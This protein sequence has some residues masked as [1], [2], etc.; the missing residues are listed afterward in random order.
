[1]VKI[2]DPEP[3]QDP[4]PDPIVTPEKPEVTYNPYDITSPKEPA[5]PRFWWHDWLPLGM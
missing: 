4:D 1:L 2:D 3:V 5:K